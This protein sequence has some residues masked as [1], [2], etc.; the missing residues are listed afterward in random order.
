MNPHIATEPKVG[1][2]KRSTQL[3]KSSWHVLKLDKELTALPIIG[4]LVSLLTIVIGG[5][6]AL[7]AYGL[8]YGGLHSENGN[9]IFYDSNSYAAQHPNPIS[10]WL[11]WTVLALTILAITFVS[12]FIATAIAKA[13]LDRFKGHDPSIK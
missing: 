1:R 6:L 11:F 4:L 12:N 9:W 3:L 5:I 7:L 10:K 2:W 8:T 13:A